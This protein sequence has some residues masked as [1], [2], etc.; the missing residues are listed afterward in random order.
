MTKQFLGKKILK[1]ISNVALFTT[2]ENV[3]DVLNFQTTKTF[4]KIKIK[5]K[6]HL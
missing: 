3:S 4:M 5:I 2:S 1:K 6:K